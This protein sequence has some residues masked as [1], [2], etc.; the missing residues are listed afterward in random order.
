MIKS[1]SECVLALLFVHLA[2]I[3]PIYAV[4]CSMPLVIAA[5]SPTKIVSN[6]VG[7]YR[8]R[9]S[10]ESALVGLCSC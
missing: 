9:K 4:L 7:E 5:C 1:N 3:V 2:D 8:K 10:A 6:V